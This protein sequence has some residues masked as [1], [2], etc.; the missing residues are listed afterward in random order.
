MKAKLVW[1]VALLT[2]CGGGAG[3]SPEQA[4]AER[5]RVQAA[6]AAGDVA[7][8]ETSEFSGDI[9]GCPEI[10]SVEPLDLDDPEVASWVAMAQGHH[11]QTL[12]WR[13][14]MLSDEVAGFAEHTSVSMDV[15]VP[16][17]R[18]VVYGSGG[19]TSSELAGCDGLRGRQIEIEITLA[20]ADGAVASTTFRNWF[21]PAPTASR[22]MVLRRDGLNP[23]GPRA[24][25]LNGT[26]E[27]RPDPALAATPRIGLEIEFGA[28]SVRGSLIPF[29]APEGDAGVSSW[30]PIEAIFPDDPCGSDGRSIGLDELFGDL[31]GTPRAYYQPAATSRAS[32]RLGAV[33][34]SLPSNVEPSPLDAPLDVPPPTEVSLDFGEPTLACAIENS[35]TVYAPVTVRTADGLVSF[36]QP[37]GFTLSDSGASING[38]TPWVPAA[39]FSEQMGLA[40]VDLEGGYGSIYLFSSTNWR[41]GGAEGTLEVSHWDAFTERRPAYAVL[42]W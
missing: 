25:D 26:L 41:N 22:G 32:Q 8:G 34:K 40:G 13:R 31:G 36:T 39:S 23:D 15:H 12:G 21:Q 10:V 37:F 20:T 11:Q 16:R 2:A 3:Q 27:L 29:V 42:E 35:V 4:R 14:L 17:G 30:A 19:S 1:G 6:G 38:R 7:G 33:W 18:E 24:V 28:D 9:V 5:A